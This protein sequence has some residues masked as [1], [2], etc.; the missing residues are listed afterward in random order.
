MLIQRSNKQAVLTQKEEEN[1]SISV[2]AKW[3]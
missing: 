1:T 2:V 3:K